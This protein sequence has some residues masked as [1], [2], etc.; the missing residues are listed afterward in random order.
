[1]R[2]QN[3]LQLAASLNFQIDPTNPIHS[4]LY[5]L[6]FKTGLK[7]QLYP[8]NPIHSHPYILNFATSLNLQCIVG[9]GQKYISPDGMQMYG[10]MD[11]SAKQVDE[12]NYI[13]NKHV[14][15]A[16]TGNKERSNNIIF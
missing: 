11:A 12:H 10:W 6:N 4:Q 14:I 8:N 5:N 9:I 15:D 1:M 2:L 16:T 13:I 7:L 3:K